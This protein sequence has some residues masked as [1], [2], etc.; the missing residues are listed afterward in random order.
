MS[1]SIILVFQQSGKVVKMDT[2]SNPKVLH[3][4]AILA[5]T[6]AL[7]SLVLCLLACVYSPVTWSPDSSKIALLVTLSEGDTNEFA[8]FTYDLNTGQRILIDKAKNDDGLSAPSWSPDGKWIAYFKMDSSVTGDDLFSEDKS[9][10]GGFQS[11]TGGVYDANEVQDSFGIKLMIATPDGQKHK[12]LKNIKS[13]KDQKEALLYMQPIWS[14]NSN[15]LFYARAV[16][17]KI[18][19]IA[20]LDI[21]SGKTVAHMPSNTFIPILSPDGNKIVSVLVV[22]QDRIKIIIANTDGKKTKSF[23]VDSY[24]KGG[25][26]L[27][28][29]FLWMPDSKHLLFLSE[30]ALMVLDVN[31]GG[32]EK[33]R[34]IGLLKI[35]GLESDLSE[36]FYV[37]ISPQGDKFYYLIPHKATDPNEKDS[38]WFESMTIKD[39]QITPIYELSQIPDY[40]AGTFFI[41]PDCKT[42]LLRAFIKDQNGKEKTALVFWDGKTHKIIETDSWLSEVF[43]PNT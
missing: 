43:D 13:L 26:N 33:L 35:E 21:T 4:V 30:N 17:S 14:E 24:K 38:V 20:S 1:F 15:R 40:E 25:I 23:I 6:I 10:L 16:A 39:K 22:E 34:D 9:Y 41:S 42:V 37:R 18:F 2:P 28:Q 36:E 3:R 27:F 32:R 8:I 7:S 11:E 31:T 19:Y 5:S 12:I 29:Q